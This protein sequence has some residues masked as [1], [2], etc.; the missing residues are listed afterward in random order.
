MINMK[1]KVWQK[2][3]NVV[4]NPRFSEKNIPYIEL[5]PFNREITPKYA[6]SIIKKLLK[7]Y[8]NFMLYST[9]LVFDGLSETNAMLLKDNFTIADK[10]T[11]ETFYV[12]TKAKN[13]I[14]KVS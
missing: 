4:I 5:I 10:Y 14:K 8:D 12:I 9:D 2:N 1:T 7:K 13:K 6:G 11:G 3:E